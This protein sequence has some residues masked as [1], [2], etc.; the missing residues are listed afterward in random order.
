[1]LSDHPRNADRRLAVTLWTALL[2]GLL[3]GPGCRRAAGPDDGPAPAVALHSTP[4]TPVK[5]PPLSAFFATVMAPAPP[6]A[7]QVERAPLPPRPPDSDQVARQ[8]IAPDPP[9][10]APVN[11][12]LI[13]CDPVPNQ[14]ALATFGVA[15]GRWLDLIAAGQPELGRTPYWESRDRARQEMGR[16]DFRLTPAQA[17]LLSGMTGATHAACG[18]ITGI[19]SRCTLTYGLYALPGGKPLGPPLVQTGAEQQVIAA[20]PGMAKA[21]DLRLGVRTPRIPAS[22]ALS[23]A[24]LTQIE[25]IGEESAAS[26]ADLL[27]LS[28]LSARSPLAGM[29]YVGTRASDDQVLLGGMVKAL[30]TQLPAN[31]LVLSHLGYAEPGALRAYAAPVRAL[32]G[33]YPGSSLFAHTEVWE[34]RIWGTRSGEW[35][36]ARRSSRDA[37]SDPDAWLSRA[38]TLA[39]IAEDLR[40]SRLANDLSAS[41]WAALRRLYGQQE[42]AALQATALDP[43]YGRAW[44]RLA[45]AATFSGD[46]VRA[47]AAFSKALAL[48]TDKQGVYFWGL[49]MYQPK[50]NGDAAALGRIAALAAAEPWGSGRRGHGRRRVAR[51]GGV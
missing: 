22:V 49:Q 32:L 14:P 2:A 23:P 4:D 5:L 21:L 31:T 43:R 41:D 51:V 45:E 1:M 46:S 8:A 30:L 29:Y 33:R 47:N 6:P 15:C 34:Q 36:A 37:P 3:L 50:W 44:L 25:R 24:E 42:Q 19:P 18:T 39:N 27:A 48:D 11:A 20:L 9:E 10:A 13:V 35:Q 16:A 7:Q 12:G 38:A 28:C 40:Q 17:G 26:D